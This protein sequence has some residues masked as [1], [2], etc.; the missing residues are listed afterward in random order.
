MCESAG[1]VN[2][3]ASG[4]A[5]DSPESAARTLRPQMPAE[6]ISVSGTAISSQSSSAPFRSATPSTAY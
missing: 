2:V 1:I 5:S 6:A 4:I 3:A